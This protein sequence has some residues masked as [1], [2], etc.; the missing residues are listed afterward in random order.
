MSSEHPHYQL[1]LRD[2]SFVSKINAIVGFYCLDTYQASA[3]KAWSSNQ[4]LHSIFPAISSGQLRE[5]LMFQDIARRL[6]K[7]F[8]S[9]TLLWILWHE[10]GLSQLSSS[11]LINL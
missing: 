10:Y 8:I 1:I 9:E 2:V 5:T 6:R 11:I 7:Y 3:D 4:K